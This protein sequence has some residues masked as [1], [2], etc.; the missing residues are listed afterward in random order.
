VTLHPAKER[1]EYAFAFGLGPS[2]EVRLSN[3]FK[4]SVEVRAMLS[5]CRQVGV[6]SLRERTE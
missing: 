2:A 4:E 3:D 1:V 5:E 6:R